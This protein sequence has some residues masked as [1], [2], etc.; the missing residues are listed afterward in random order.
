[1]FKVI[2]ALIG[3]V[4]IFATTNVYAGYNEDFAA[5]NKGMPNSVQQFNRRQ[6]ECNHWAG[7]EPYDKARLKQINTAVA[8]LKCDALEKDER[9][10]LKKYKSKPSIIDSINKA[11]EFAL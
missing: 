7:E 11:K 2:A 9:K 6:I 3:C 10:L 1:M 5:I 4:F 8:I